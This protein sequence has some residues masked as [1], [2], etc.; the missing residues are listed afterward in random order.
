MATLYGQNLRVWTSLGLNAETPDA[1]IIACAT[2]CTIQ[3]TADTQ[4]FSHKDILNVFNNP[5]VSNLRCQVTT[6]A[7]DVENFSIILGK[8]LNKEPVF[9]MWDESSGNLNQTP[10]GDDWRGSG[11]AYISDMTL[12]ANNRELAT[13]STTFTIT[14]M[15]RHDDQT[16]PSDEDEF[17]NT[18]G[19]RLRLVLRKTS[20]TDAVIAAALQLSFH[21]SVSL[22]DCTTK[23]THT[24]GNGNWIY[25]EPTSI[26]YDISSTALVRSGETITSQKGG[27]SMKE[28][29]DKFE[30]ASEF[31]WGIGY[32]SGTNY[33]DVD[34][35]VNGFAIITS[36][37]VNGPNR[38]KATYSIQ[39]QGVGAYRF[40]SNAS[41]S[42]ALNS[43]NSGT[44]SGEV[45]P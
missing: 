41:H 4:D 7:L 5:T 2:N 16:Q 31:R 6:E 34:E 36:L 18:W 26:S 37:Q 43:S 12:N 45:T 21:V 24:S 35:M 15:V 11:M 25:V 14:G 28:A 32:A 19:E 9:I 22:E 39:L 29:Q 17:L 10:A 1:R 13:L 8:V 44:D 3:Y 40:P 30:T 38:Q 42:N 27:I 20:V 33:R 23:D